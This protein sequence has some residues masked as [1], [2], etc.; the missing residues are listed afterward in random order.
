LGQ[1]KIFFINFIGSS[2]YL[3]TSK[4]VYH[5]FTSDTA[6]KVLYIFVIIPSV[7]PDLSEVLW[8]IP[9]DIMLKLYGIYFQV[10]REFFLFL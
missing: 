3:V 5:R 2:H 7:L 10:W 4:Q 9:S 8:L 6:R 1:K